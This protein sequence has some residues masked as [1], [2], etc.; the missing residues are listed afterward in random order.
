MPDPAVKSPRPLDPDSIGNLHGTIQCAE[1]R[2]ANPE[3]KVGK[4]EL[5][6][7]EGGGGDR[8]S[9]DGP[10]AGT[11]PSRGAENVKKGVRPANNH[12]K[13]ATC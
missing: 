2:R 6:G 9:W 4:G 13:T 12:G 1:N 8:S 11:K 7:R 10:R 3:G 5:R